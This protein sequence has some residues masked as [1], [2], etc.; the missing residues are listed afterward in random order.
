VGGQKSA[1]TSAELYHQQEQ[2][3]QIQ[4]NYTKVENN[5]NKSE[6]VLKSIGSTWG[7]VKS[8]FTK[9]K[10]T[11]EIKDKDDKEDQNKK[12]N[13][14]PDNNAE[15]KST[16][17]SNKSNID[18][19]DLDRQID[20]MRNNILANTVK[21]KEEAI[22]QGKAIEK[23]SKKVGGLNDQADKINVREKKVVNTINTYIK[24]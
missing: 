15:S 10:V 12:T 23:T 8:L 14:K 18:Q 22:L 4:K 20:E 9:P 7:M 17:T 2:L 1:Y 21:L 13:N 19:S 5:L 11:K 16:T 3:K 6:W 24:K